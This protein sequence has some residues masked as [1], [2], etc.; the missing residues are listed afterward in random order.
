MSEKFWYWQLFLIHHKSFDI[1]ISYRFRRTTWLWNQLV[2]A[3]WSLWK[4]SIPS[5][6]IRY[7]CLCWAEVCYP[8]CC[9]IAGIIIQEI[10][11]L[12]CEL[13]F[14][15]LLLRKIVMKTIWIIKLQNCKMLNFVIW[16]KENKSYGNR[17][18]NVM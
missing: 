18:C 4:C 1:G 10:R 15:L 9:H 12:S 17:Q 2:C 5:F 7:A 16:G 14:L 6:W 11:G 13:L 8:S 3:K